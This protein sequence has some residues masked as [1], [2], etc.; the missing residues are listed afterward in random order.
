MKKFL[1]LL[2]IISSLLGCQRNMNNT[3][4]GVYTKLPSSADPLNYDLIENHIG[5]TSVN[6]PLVSTYEKGK[7]VGRIAENWHH[8]D[9]FKE[10]TFGIR[11]NITFT[12]GTPIDPKSVAS[13]F[14]RLAIIKKHTKSKSG[15][16]ENLTGYEDLKN[17]STD[18]QGISFNE[19]EIKL[20]FNVPV[21]DLL[22]KISFGIYGI[23]S[24]KNFDSIDGHWT[25][26][27]NN[28]IT[29]GPYELVSFD[30]SSFSIRL[31]EKYPSELLPKNPIKKFSLKIM[32]NIKAS[33]DL[34]DVDLVFADK[35][36]VKVSKEFQFK[37]VHEDSK[38]LYV[39][40]LNPEG[41]LGKKENRVTLRDLFLNT[42]EDNG[43]N[44]ERSFFPLSINNIKKRE[45]I[46]APSDKILERFQVQELPAANPID[47]AANTISFSGLAVQS[48]NELEKK[49]DLKFVTSNDYSIAFKATGINLENPIEDV[50]FMFLSKQGINLPDPSGEIKKELSKDNPSLEF[51]NNQLWN[52]GLIWPVTHSGSGFWI[53][54]KSKFEEKSLNLINEAF[55]L[56]SIELKE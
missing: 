36:T 40:V 43:V 5:F 20:K 7:V 51:V 26:D 15:L 52:D 50:R 17:A 37:N 42:M 31:R 13:N 4:I 22:T 38:I 24:P 12:D 18:I 49:Y 28:V 19:N 35:G 27:A 2:L 33:S 54:K 45:R 41:W 23:T 46:S 1:F 8:S 25:A 53:K 11:K 10:W 55:D 29:S 6:I 32:S 48:L 9:D 14:L 21:R 34:N 47:N 44:V 30:K 39:Q 3:I 56:Q 16:L